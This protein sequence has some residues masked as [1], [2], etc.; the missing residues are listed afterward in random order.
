MFVMQSNMTLTANF[1]T[2]LFPPVQTTYNGLFSTSNGVTEETAGMLSGLTLTPTG[3]FSG[4]LFIAGTTNRFSGN[5]SAAG[6]AS[7]NIGTVSAAVGALVVD[8]IFEEGA[9]NQIV[10][11]VS[12]VSWVAPLT[13]EQ[14]STNQPTNQYTMLFSNVSGITPPGEGY[15]WISNNAGTAWLVGAL[16]DGTPFS[17]GISVSQFGDIPVYASLYNNTG[18]LIGWVNLTNMGASPPINTLTWI[19]QSSGGASLYPDGFTN[20]LS[21]QG[22]PWTMPPANTAAINMTKGDLL[23]TNTSSNLDFTVAVLANN[24]LAKLGGDPPNSLTGSINRTNGLFSVTFGYGAGTVKGY[25]AILQ[26]QTNGGG[27]FQT[28]T[29]AGELILQP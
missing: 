4:K 27:Y 12:N 14:A 17:Q 6:Q 29:N 18:L 21:V 11:T 13:I 22:S 7:V 26:S 20:T 9:T 28:A 16:A 24:T 25:G 8:L 5:F 1:V 2:N 19:E 10:G 23:V 15:A 3:F